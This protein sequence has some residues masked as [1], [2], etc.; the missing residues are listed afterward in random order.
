MRLSVNIGSSCS[1]FAKLQITCA[2]ILRALKPIITSRFISLLL[3][4]V[5]S[6]PSSFDRLLINITAHAETLVMK[7]NQGNS[8]DADEKRFSR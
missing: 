7:Y 5:R 2:E 3:G 1:Q 4:L 8:Q 6:M